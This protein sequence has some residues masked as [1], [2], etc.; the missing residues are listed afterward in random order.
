MIER[1]TNPSVKFMVNKDNFNKLM[2]ILSFQEENIV[3]EEWKEKVSKLK[4]MLLMYPI[5]K[6]DENGD[7]AIVDVALYPKEA[8][9]LIVLLI[10]AFEV[11]EADRDYTE[12]MKRK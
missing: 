6:K 4:K 11:L 2:T 12:L 9:E 10:S 1:V 7:I 5:P 3:T 8:S